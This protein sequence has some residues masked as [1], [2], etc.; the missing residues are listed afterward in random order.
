MTTST[1]WI[2]PSCYH[3]SARSPGALTLQFVFG[4]LLSC[5]ERSFADERRIADFDPFRRFGSEFSMAGV[6]PK[7]HLMNGGEL[8]VALTFL[9]GRGFPAQT[10]T[11]QDADIA[12]GA[13]MRNDRALCELVVPRLIQRHGR[14]KLRGRSCQSNRA[15]QDGG[16]E[17]PERPV[18][19]IFFAAVEARILALWKPVVS[20]INEHS[21]TALLSWPGMTQESLTNNQTW[22]KARWLYSA[23]LEAWQA[24]ARMFGSTN[25]TETSV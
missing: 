14:G 16:F 24:I 13:R 18:K 22:H 7:R 6:D 8:V 1:F 11:M 3:L 4:R 17:R 20:G 15:L 5:Q 10:F 12:F 23:T 21:Q 2:F 19:F 9:V 25:F